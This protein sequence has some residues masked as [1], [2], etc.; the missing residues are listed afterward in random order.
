MPNFHRFTIK[1]QEALQNAQEIAAAKNHGE[2]K[3]LH[4]LM[5]LLNDESSLVIPIV[6]R[7]GVNVELL[8]DDIEEALESMPKLSNM[9]NVSQLFLSQEFMRIL[10][11][12]AKIAAQQKDEFVSCEHFLLAILE[13]P[14]TAS[15]IVERAGL[16][17]ETD[18]AIFT[19][20]RGASRVTD[21]TP[22]SKFQVLEKYAINLTEKARKGE[23]DPVIGREDELR[24]L[25][26]VSP[27]APRITRS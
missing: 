9:A 19:N 2:L 1:A 4:L 27:A 20:L 23:L 26:Q 22:E 3:A 11:Q 14:S 16:R 10:D 24:R 8:R 25:M 13:V 5:A 17:R 6:T 12:A 7:A 18:C 15:H 21:E